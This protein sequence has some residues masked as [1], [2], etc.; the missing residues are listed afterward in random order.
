MP[1]SV[2]ARGRSI[3]GPQSS[4]AIEAILSAIQQDLAAIRTFLATHQHAALNAAPS[5]SP[6]A[7]NT[8]P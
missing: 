5:T 8:Q 1:E 6:P 3:G 4:R 2:N 7:L